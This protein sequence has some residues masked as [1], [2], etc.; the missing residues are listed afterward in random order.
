MG[1]QEKNTFKYDKETLYQGWHVID[2]KRK[3]IDLELE[4]SSLLVEET[5][6][7]KCWGGKAGS[8]WRFIWLECFIYKGQRWKVHLEK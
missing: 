4:G 7:Q 8:G 1:L 6:Q 2:I 5:A 3:K